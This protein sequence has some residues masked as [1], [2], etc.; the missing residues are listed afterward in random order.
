M[1]IFEGNVSKFEVRKNVMQALDAASEV[2]D[3]AAV[4]QNDVDLMRNTF[5]IGDE[6]FGPTE[7]E[8]LLREYDEVVEKGVWPGI[9]AK[10]TL[11]RGMIATSVDSLATS[12][13]NGPA[14]ITVGQITYLRTLK[15]DE[16]KPGN[17][18]MRDMTVGEARREITALKSAQELTKKAHWR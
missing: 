16:N 1:K 2:H 9:A 13:E 15:Y 10:A 3:L 5:S 12:V 6:L 18:K 17:K 8:A 14:M 4:T 7:H 11:L